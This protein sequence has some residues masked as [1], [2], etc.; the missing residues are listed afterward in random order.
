MWQIHFCPQCGARAARSDRF[1][2]ACGL[3]LTC[4]VRPVPPPSYDYQ[5]AYQ[6]W[7][8]HSPLYNQAAAHVDSN[9]Y[10]HG[11]TVTPI[12]TEISQLLADFFDKRLKH[13][14]V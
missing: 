12:S 5:C 2:G 1:C 4:V 6:Q 8:P 3:D 10:Q 7:V 11:D 13:D 9:Q 14:K